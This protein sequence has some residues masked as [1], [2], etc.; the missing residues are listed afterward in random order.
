MKYSICLLLG[1]FFLQSTLRADPMDPPSIA[2]LRQRLSGPRVGA[3]QGGLFEGAP[4]TLQQF[5]RAR[6]AGMDIVEMDLR[7]TKDGVAVVYHDPNLNTWTTCSGPV[8]AKTLAEIRQCAYKGNHQPI[9]TFEEV[10]QWAQGRIV[11]DAEFKDIET[12][13]PA[14]RLVQQYN[15]LS[16]TYFQAQGNREKYTLA[17][18]LDPAVALLFAVRNPEDRDWALSLHDPGMLIIE[19][20]TKDVTDE[21][22]ALFKAA[23]KLIT[24][25]VFGFVWHRE[26]FGAACRKGFSK[27]VDLAISNQTTRCVKQKPSA[28]PLSDEID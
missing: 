18:S 12:I 27:G 24:A 26:L 21:N 17:R 4:N 5:E 16:W 22:V 23:G 1:V 2:E 8:K 28:Q 3:H 14:V 25:D 15:A 9:S 20:D 19:L 6:K 13:E 11:V 10:L 7:I